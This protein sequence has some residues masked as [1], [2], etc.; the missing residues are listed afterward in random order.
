MPVK[1]SSAL[2]FPSGHLQFPS[3]TS[4]PLSGS[5]RLGEAYFQTADDAIYFGKD[6]NTFEM[7]P[8]VPSASAV[9]GRVMIWNGTGGM[10]STS[11]IYYDPV[12]TALCLGSNTPNGDPVN[13]NLLDI[14][15]TAN[16]DG[17]AE[18]ALHA[19]V[20]ASPTVDVSYGTQAAR[21][22]FSIAS[23]NTKNFTGSVEAHRSLLGLDG[24]GQVT[25]ATASAAW[26]SSSNPVTWLSAVYGTARFSGSGV[27]TSAVGLESDVQNTASGT[28]TSAYGVHVSSPI[29][30]LISGSVTNAYLYYGKR[31]PSTGPV[32][33]L[34]GLYLEDIDQGQ[35][36]NYA[37]KT[38]AGV[39]YFGDDV[40][41]QGALKLV[42]GTQQNGYVLTSDALGNTSWQPAAASAFDFADADVPSGLDVDGLT[43]GVTQAYVLAHTPSPASSLFFVMNGR[44]MRPGATGDFTLSGATVTFTYVPPPG[45]WI[46][47][48]YRY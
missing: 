26:A 37:I 4:L 48:W 5:I 18:V 41:I 29:A 43:D 21:S 8:K 6:V 38:G 32:T 3:G 19:S 27:A 44:V 7:I 47:A 35:T 15:G 24:S 2:Q 28:T 31:R 9:S 13:P 33:N 11:K 22:M 14:G 16:S 12:T 17:Y 34:Y 30:S 40:E 42:D 45:L 20:L 10:T 1:A 36:L 25:L 46:L 39:V 23:G